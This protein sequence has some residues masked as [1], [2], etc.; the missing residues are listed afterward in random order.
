MHVAATSVCSPRIALKALE[1][2]E[3]I[4]GD[5]EDGRNV[6]VRRIT[7]IAG[8]AAQ[9]KGLQTDQKTIERGERAPAKCR[10][11]CRGQG[12][13]S[14]TL[15][16]QI[17]FD[18]STFTKFDRRLLFAMHEPEC[19]VQSDKFNRRIRIR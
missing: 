7:V 2:V 17:L 4:E 6:H 18:R 19:R 11:T 16:M 8:L 13:Q 5:H 3:Q 15:D 9:R 10:Q 1:Q 14:E 12:A